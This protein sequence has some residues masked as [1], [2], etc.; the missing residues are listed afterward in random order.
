M[1]QRVVRGHWLRLQVD[2]EAAEG[3]QRHGLT[4]DWLIQVGFA[5]PRPCSSP[6]PDT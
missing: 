3:G 6:L 4:P 2:A 1:V 5:A